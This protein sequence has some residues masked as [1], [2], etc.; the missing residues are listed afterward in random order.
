MLRKRILHLGK[1]ENVFE[2]CNKHC[3][4]MDANFASKTFPRL[5]TEETNKRNNVSAP[6]FSSLAR[7]L[8]YVASK[9]QW[10]PSTIRMWSVFQMVA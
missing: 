10:E 2:S 6:M 8:I 1:Q 4:F 7:P 5:P 3:C 9:I